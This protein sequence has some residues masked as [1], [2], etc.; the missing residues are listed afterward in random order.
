MDSNCNG[1]EGFGVGPI[2]QCR[3]CDEPFSAAATCP[4]RVHPGQYRMPRSGHE[5]AGAGWTCCGSM[6]M[7]A[8]P[9][10]VTHARHE[11]S[12][13]APTTRPTWGW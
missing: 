7:Q 1:S 11:L 3:N 12:A 5:W 6:A 4:R 8:V 2:K 13:P 9:C 10:T